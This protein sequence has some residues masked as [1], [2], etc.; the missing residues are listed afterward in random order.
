MNALSLPMARAFRD[1]A[2]RLTSDPAVRAILISAEGRAFMAGGDLRYFHQA[3]DKPAAAR[4]LIACVN[5]GLAALDRPDAIILAALQ[6]AVAGGGTVS[7]THLDVYK[8]QVTSRAIVGP[9]HGS[10]PV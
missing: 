10:V 6:G 2:L 7:Y 8:R 5:E 4:E 3:A 1:A 9:G